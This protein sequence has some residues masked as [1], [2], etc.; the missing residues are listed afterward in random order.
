MGGNHTASVQIVAIIPRKPDGG[1]GGATTW[2][3]APPSLGVASSL[4]KATINLR[5]AGPEL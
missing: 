3:E 4:A 5:S 1:G 2:A